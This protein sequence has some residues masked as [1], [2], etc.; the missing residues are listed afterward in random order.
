M[1]E[2]LKEKMK[3]RFARVLGNESGVTLIE[4]LA[5]VVILAIIAAVAVPAVMSQFTTSKANVDT[6]NEKILSDAINRFIVQESSSYKLTLPGSTVTID[7]TKIDGTGSNVI[8]FSNGPSTLAN[9]DFYTVLTSTTY[10]G[11]YIQSIPSPK[12][13]GDTKWSV[14]I[15]NNNQV[16]KIDPIP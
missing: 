8:A 14:T 12:T 3:K 11:P 1:K 6:Q 16:T 2:T 7:P 4:L 13:S 10:G 5:V 15:D 9:A